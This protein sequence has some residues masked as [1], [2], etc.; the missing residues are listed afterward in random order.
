MKVV[1][2]DRYGDFEPHPVERNLIST[3]VFWDLI[4]DVHG[5]SVLDLGCGGGD[6]AILLALAGARVCAVDESEAAIAAARRQA[7]F[8]RAPASEWRCASAFGLGAGGKRFDLITGR[9]ILHHIE[10][11]GDFVLLLHGSLK[12]GGRAV[13]IENSARNPLLMLS[14]RHLVGR[15]GLPSR[16]DGTERPFPA[17]K[18]RML[19]KTFNRV[20]VVYPE[21]VL[22]RLVARYFFPKN[23][24]WAG[25]FNRMDRLAYRHF[26]GLRKYGYVQVIVAEK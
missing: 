19:K 12:P 8:N 22:F 26:P 20:S 7:S 15:F 21:L 9:Y 13:F 6:L 17:S 11:F 2:D 14:R 1:W 18:L 23:E 24:Y 10:P 3:D 5:K 16:S 4:G 25:R